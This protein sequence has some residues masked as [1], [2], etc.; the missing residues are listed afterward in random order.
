LYS[1]PTLPD[2]KIYC[3]SL[4]VT[5]IYYRKSRTRKCVSMWEAYICTLLFFS[6]LLFMSHSFWYHL[7]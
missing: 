2:P 7:C 6:L 5:D 1:L 4:V 3:L